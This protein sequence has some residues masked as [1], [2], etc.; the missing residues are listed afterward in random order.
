MTARKP[1]P[2]LEDAL[3]FGRAHDGFTALDPRTN[4]KSWT[5]WRDYFRWLNWVPAWFIEVERQ[6][7]IDR[8][9]P[10]TWTAPVDHPDKFT[11]KFT[12]C[13]GPPPE[14]PMTRVRPAVFETKERIEHVKELRARGALSFGLPG[15]KFNP[16]SKAEAQRIL[17]EYARAAQPFIPPDTSEVPF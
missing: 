13:K 3:K 6:H 15:S 10:A 2:W 4:P 5:A 12:Q 1:N 9:S 11:P 17:D 16:H 8:A 14:F 7:C